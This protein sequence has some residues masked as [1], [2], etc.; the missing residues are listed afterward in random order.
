MNTNIH[1]EPIVTD[2]QSVRGYVHV[3][4]KR[5]LGGYGS[6]GVPVTSA[7]DFTCQRCARLFPVPAVLCT[8]FETALDRNMF[9]FSAALPAPSFCPTCPPF[10]E[11]RS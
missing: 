3:N 5:V 2:W 9:W 6:S 11:A 7:I 4:G 1:G 8:R 10:G